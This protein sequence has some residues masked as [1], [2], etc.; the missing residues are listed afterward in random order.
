MLQKSLTILIGVA[1]LAA[2]ASETPYGPSEGGG[3]YGFSEQRIEDNRYRITFRGNSL[4]SRE[5]V[6][7]YLLYRA[8]E[9]TLN[10]GHDYF[11]VVGDDT[12]KTT[13]YRTTRDPYYYRS[14]FPYYAYGYRWAHPYRD[15]DIKASTRY[16]AV[17]YIVMYKGE[18]PK[19]PA[20]YDARQVQQN[21]AGFIRREEAK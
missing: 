17:A 3:G 6:E 2:C 13:T 8:A 10:S 11:V 21:L 7:N 18:K 20:A 5:T 1:L 15:V 12:E 19:N 9:K 4:T 16:S 14:P